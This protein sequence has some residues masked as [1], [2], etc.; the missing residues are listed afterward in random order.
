ME[1]C[2]HIEF[3]KIFQ[4]ISHNDDDDF[5]KEQNIFLHVWHK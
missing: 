1:F 2:E 3:N 4:S 5:E